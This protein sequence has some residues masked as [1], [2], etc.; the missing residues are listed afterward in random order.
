MIHYFPKPY[1]D[2]LWYSVICRYHIWSGNQAPIESIREL[3]SGRDYVDVG[4]IFPSNSIHDIAVQLPGIINIEDIVLNHTLFNYAVRIYPYEEKKKMLKTIFDG[5][6]NWPGKLCVYH[7]EKPKLKYCPLCIKEDI[8]TYGEPYWHNIHQIPVINICKKHLCRL[9]T[10]YCKGTKDLD[11]GLIS[12]LKCTDLTIDTNIKDYEMSIQSIAEKYFSLPL[13]VGPSYEF[14][15]IF[16][17]LQNAGYGLLRKD[18]GFIL[19][20]TEITEDLYRVFDKAFID[21][22]FTEK[23]L[24][25]DLSKGMRNW[26]I[27]SPER[28]II[29]GTLINQEPDITFSKHKVENKFKIKLLDIQ[30]K[31]NGE[32]K[33]MIA[34]NLGLKDYMLDSICQYY[35]VEKFWKKEDKNETVVIHIKMTN[36][37]KTEMY[38]YMQMNGIKYFNNFI[39]DCIRK[40]IQ[41]NKNKREM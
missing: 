33:K 23:Q 9:K 3:F 16:E 24:G 8:K 10:Y 2:E 19:K 31:Y 32:S 36:K 1:P 27:K 5:C 25:R 12:P 7:T 11:M 28:Y 34:K 35:E 39:L 17:G 37:E 15:N 41:H 26:N 38:K 14:N 29:L 13:E 20:A 40:E 4:T 30:K 18:T 21:Y 6:L 22:F